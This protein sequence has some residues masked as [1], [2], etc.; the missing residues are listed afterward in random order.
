[1]LVLTQNAVEAITAIKSSTDEVPDE[2]G[3][4]I[5]A[6]V[7]GPDEVMLNLAIVPEPSESDVVVE[8]AGEQVFLEPDVAPF[9]TD[10][11]LDAQVEEGQVT[12]AVGLQAG[13]D[14]GGPTG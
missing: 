8:A 1:M 12:F 7:A 5:S 10:K 6:D 13:T 3:L 14:S 9:L 4:R 11:V 2:A